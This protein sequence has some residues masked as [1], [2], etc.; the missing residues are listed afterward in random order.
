LNIVGLFFSF[1]GRMG[2]ARY[3]A[4]QLALLA[5]WF[6]LVVGPPLHFSAQW[7]ALLFV[8]GAIIAMIWINLATT[9]KR[10]HDRNRSGWWA[11]AIL[12]LNRLA[13]VYYGLFFGISFGVD[14]SIA[15]EL[16]LVLL[17]A[18]MSL[19][20]TGILIELFFLAGTEGT[21]QYGPDSTSAFTGP[22]G[23][24]GPGPY[25]VP[26]FLLRRAGTSPA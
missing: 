20:Q 15:E 6:V 17:A 4:V 16:L 18:A 12:V 8:C 10:L 19:L 22:P 13:Y 14:I 7:Q 23:A 21:N 1:R 11:I 24:S 3:L 9:V 5:L 25:G 26:D 2:R